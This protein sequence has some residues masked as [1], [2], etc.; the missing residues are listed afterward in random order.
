MD[1][2]S[3]HESFWYIEIQETNIPK[4]KEGAIYKVYWV[5]LCLN[6]EENLE[7]NVFVYQVLT[8]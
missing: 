6:P 2:L 7:R 3:E 8:W 5:L 1:V 4:W